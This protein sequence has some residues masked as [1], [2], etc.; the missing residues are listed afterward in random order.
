MSLA[1]KLRLLRYY[2]GFVLRRDKPMLPPLRLWVDITSRCNLKCESCPQRRLGELE[3]RDMS[4]SLLNAICNQINGW[5]CEVNLFHRGEPLLHP[6]LPNWIR[7]FK[8]AGALVRIHTNATLFNKQ[9]IAGLLWAGPD[10]LTCSIDSLDAKA[11]AKAR[12]GAELG[13]TLAGLEHLLAAKKRLGREKPYISLLTMGDEPPGKEAAISLARLQAR[14]LNRLVHRKPHNWAGLTGDAVRRSK[15]A[16]CT[17][18]WY[19]LAVLSD[20]RVTPCPQDFMGG[21]VLGRMPDEGLLSI[22][23]GA[24]ARV[25][26][27]A[28]A[29]HDLSP[30]PICQNCDRVYRPTIMGVPM[31]HARNFVNESLFQR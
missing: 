8:Q 31:E 19:G 11:Y 2:Q 30:F 9:N 4:P 12:V 21:M 7:R 5:G 29:R 20:G 16:V 6:D 27:M 17:F 26:R 14:G 10:I 25:L 13:R 1:A 28:H 18:P 23:R 24:W 3:R 22:W 15:P